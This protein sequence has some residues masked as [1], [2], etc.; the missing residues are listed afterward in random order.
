MVVYASSGNEN[1]DESDNEPK[2]SPEEASND[3][4]VVDQSKASVRT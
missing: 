3:A 4:P 2:S 1:G